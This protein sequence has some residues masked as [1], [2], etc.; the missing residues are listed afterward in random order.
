MYKQALVLNKLQGLMWCK[1]QPTV[2]L[3]LFSNWGCEKVRLK[4]PV[5]LR[6]LS[7]PF[8]VSS[9][10]RFSPSW[11]CPK[12]TKSKVLLIAQG[13]TGFIPFSRVLDKK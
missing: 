1:T 7:N 6:S 3:L 4:E 12:Q 10:G 13:M 8:S 2:Y 9:C 11:P 5:C